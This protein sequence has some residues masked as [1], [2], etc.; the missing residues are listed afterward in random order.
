MHPSSHQ[1]LHQP[2]KERR[3]TTSRWL[4]EETFLLATHFLGRFLVRLLLE[5]G[6][7]QEARER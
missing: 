4:R 5:K 1:A 2:F 3:S 6:R 7:N